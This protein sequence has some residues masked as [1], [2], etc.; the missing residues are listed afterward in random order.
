MIMNNATEIKVNSGQEFAISLKA[1]P[2]TGYNWEAEFDESILKL[3]EKIFEPDSSAVIGGGGKD[4]FVFLPIK[5]GKTEII[6]LYKRS[7][8]NSYVEEK[9][10]WINIE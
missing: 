5:T 2:T 10:F 9:V 1:N 7:W 4:K 8:E 3:K 6:M